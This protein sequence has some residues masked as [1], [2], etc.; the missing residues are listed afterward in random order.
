[1]FIFLFRLFLGYLIAAWLSSS[2]SLT[3]SA[4]AWASL[5]TYG[6]LLLGYVLACIAIWCGVMLLGLMGI[7]TF[8]AG[9]WIADR[10]RGR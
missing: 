10:V 4:T 9:A 5:W 8:F 2:V 3:L 6:A 7:G 1:M